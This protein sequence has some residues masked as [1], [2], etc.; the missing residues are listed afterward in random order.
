MSIRKTVILGLFTILNL[1][2]F[3]QMDTAWVRRYNGLGDS[4]DFAQA[5]VVDQ[6]GYIYVTGSG[7]GDGSD[8]DYTTIKY[9]SEGDTL[10]VR[11]YNGL[12]NYQDVANALA[13]DDSGNVYVTGYSWDDFLFGYYNYTTI[14]YSPT[15]DAIWVRRYDGPGNSSDAAQSVAVDDSGNVYVTGWSVVNGTDFDYATIKYSPAGESLWVRRYNGPGNDRDMAYALTLDML[16]N[17]YVTGSSDNV[18]SVPDY[19]TIKYTAT[20]DSVWVRHYNGPGNSTDQPYALAVDG[21]GNVYVTGSS[22]GGISTRGDYATIKYDQNG[23]TLWERRYN[24]SGNSADVAWDIKVDESGKVYVAGG[25]LSLTTHMDF[26][27]IKYNSNGDTIWA[28]FYNG[29]DNQYDQAFKLALDTQGN[30]YVTGSS[31]RIGQYDDFLTVKYDSVGNL[32]WSARYNGPG[33]LIDQPSALAVDNDGNAYVSGYSDGGASSYDFTTIKYISVECTAKSGDADGDGNINLADL[34][35]TVNFIF[36]AGP[37]PDPPCRGDANV[38]GKINLSD[39]INLVNY[40][41]KNGPPPQ[42]FS[43]CCL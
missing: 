20:G 8:F 19:T 14:K 18:F 5:L 15:G 35:F 17:V 9:A 41:F 40:L 24:G 39:I 26:G 34:I 2:A 42:K 7:W 38:D 31:V 22:W 25:T 13:V 12:G 11:H 37:K 16:G 32:L 23:N 28:R 6:S 33:N 10:W 4:S 36:K 27:T 30:V 1:P 3:A 21:Q 43:V 29:E